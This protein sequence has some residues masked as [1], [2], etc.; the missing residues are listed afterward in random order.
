VNSNKTVRGAGSGAI[1]KGVSFNIA[2]K[3][4]IIVQNLT[5][6]EINPS[7]IEAG[8]ALTINT[9]HHVW[10]DHCKFSMISDGYLDIR[11]GSSAVT[12][13]NNVI[14]G[15]NAY[16]CDGQHNF[17]SLVSDSQV[18]Y[19]HN[20]FDHVGGRNPKATDSATV[21]LYNN[22]YNSVSYFCTAANSSAQV[23]VENNY[24]YNSNYPH[25]VDGGTIE[26]SGN[27][28]AGTTSATH[29][30]SNGTVFNPPYAYTLESASS[31]NTTVPAKA[32][33]GKY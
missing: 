12:V 33:P 5:I 26:A 7:L 15:A 13:S 18:S 9:S 8:D 4:N 19:H 11:Y 24:Y 22:Y 17:V 1:L 6:S 27:V 10:V 20:Y 23:L 32:G 30:D 29:R 16:V 14:D 31:L 25:W 21:H 2:N 3:S 28:Y